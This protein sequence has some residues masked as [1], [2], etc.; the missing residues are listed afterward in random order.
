[1]KY[2]YTKNNHKYWEWFRKPIF[3]WFFTAC[4]R[5]LWIL[6]RR[7]FL[8]VVGSI[9]QS[10]ERE[11]LPLLRQQAAVVTLVWHQRGVRELNLGTHTKEKLDNFQSFKKKVFI[12]SFFRL[13]C[14]IQ[15]DDVG[16]YKRRYGHHLSDLSTLPRLMG[17][18]NC[19]ALCLQ[20]I[21]YN[22]SDN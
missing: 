13:F 4:V 12:S 21:T 6:R 7:T 17:S 3:E 16:L 19:F 2:P 8:V 1:M 22:Y 5:S 9:G 10:Q 18:N 14:W 15:P 11:V 20:L